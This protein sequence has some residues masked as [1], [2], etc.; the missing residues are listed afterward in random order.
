MHVEVGSY[1]GSYEGCAGTLGHIILH[2]WP[3][4]TG[5]ARHYSMMLPSIHSKLSCLGDNALM[6]FLAQ[7]QACNFIFTANHYS[8]ILPSTNHTQK[9]TSLG[10]DA[11]LRFSYAGQHISSG[12][13]LRHV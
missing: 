7:P 13:A 4:I 5:V 9:S 11:V 1:E 8:M 3:V 12:I 2:Y 10:D 6:R